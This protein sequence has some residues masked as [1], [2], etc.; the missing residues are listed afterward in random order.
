MIVQEIQCRSILTKSGIE[1][2]DYAINPYVGCAHACVY[3]YATFMKRFTGHEEEWGTFVDVRVNAPDMLRRQLRRPKAG[4][5]FLSS[6]TDAYQPLEK[7]Y[8]LTRAC[9]EAL[10]GHDDLSVSI[11]TKSALVRRDIDV[12]RR[13]HEPSVGF[14]ITSLDEALRKRFEPGAS[15]VE[16]RLEAMQELAAAG[17][18]TWAFTGPL[19]PFLS[20]SDEQIDALFRAVKEAGGYGVLVDSLNLYTAVWGR[21]KRV[22]EKQYP[23]LVPLYLEILADRGPYHQALMARARRMADRH[24]LEWK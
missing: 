22:I 23:E 16:A 18:S 8:G 19:L 21:M 11:L 7:R 15:S 2:V 12:L 6:V 14:T 13:L 5:V 4:T 10:V 20:D 1:G 3:C 24:G 17:I 9:L